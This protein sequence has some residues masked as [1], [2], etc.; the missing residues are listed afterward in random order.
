MFANVY[1]FKRS[2]YKLISKLVRISRSTVVS[3]PTP[4]R[5]FKWCPGARDRIHNTSFPL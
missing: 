2:W 4:H 5:T 3:L 1:K